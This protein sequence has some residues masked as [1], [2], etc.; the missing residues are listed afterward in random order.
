MRY[1]RMVIG[2]LLFLYFIPKMMIKVDFRGPIFPLN[3]R[4]RQIRGLNLS[5]LILDS[6]K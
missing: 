5:P 6:A 3:P 1:E 4:F 2:L